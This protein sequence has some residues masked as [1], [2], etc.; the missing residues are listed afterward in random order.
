LKTFFVN[1]LLLYHEPAAI[2]LQLWLVEVQLL[3][4]ALPCAEKLGYE[5][6]KPGKYVAQKFH[7]HTLTVDAQW[8]EKKRKERTIAQGFHLKPAF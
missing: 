2:H 3:L 6:G 4:G 7:V 5:F 8:K 1:S